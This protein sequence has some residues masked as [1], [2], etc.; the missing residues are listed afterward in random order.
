MDRLKE[1]NGRDLKDTAPILVKR[2]GIRPVQITVYYRSMLPVLLIKG[3]VQYRSETGPSVK[4]RSS[5]VP[6]L[7]RYRPIKTGNAPVFIVDFRSASLLPLNFGQEK[8]GTGSTDNDRN[9][10][11]TGTGMT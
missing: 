11:R 1:R 9:G 8:N 7:E 3:P 2:T 6:V 4:N 10:K 5:T